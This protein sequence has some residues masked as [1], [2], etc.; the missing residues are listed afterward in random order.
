M[1]WVNAIMNGFI[2][3]IP[4]AGTRKALSLIY[5]AIEFGATQGDDGTLCKTGDT[6]VK[7]VFVDD[8]SHE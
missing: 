8:L 6:V 5:Q 4:D 3:S 7:M 2:D 1:E